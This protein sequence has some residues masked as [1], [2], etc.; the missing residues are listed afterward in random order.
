MSN[1]QQYKFN[2]DIM[3]ILSMHRDD[4]YEAGTRGWTKPN[5]PHQ[6]QSWAI[7]INKPWRYDKIDEK[8][9]PAKDAPIILRSS[10]ES[11]TTVY[12]LLNGEMAEWSREGL[13]NYR[14]AINEVLALWDDLDEQE[15]KLND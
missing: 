3:N 11:N 5:S 9:E 6:H 7:F 13:Q 10:V 12:G 1:D 15:A 14:D 4:D 2:E 8:E